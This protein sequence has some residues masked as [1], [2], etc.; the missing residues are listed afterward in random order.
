MEEKLLLEPGSNAL[1]D[2]KKAEL[3]K[4]KERFVF[5]GIDFYYPTGFIATMAR[6]R[7]FC[8]I[9]VPIQKLQVARCN[10]AYWS[11]L[12]RWRIVGEPGM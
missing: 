12:A 11:E 10:V 6:F 8:A 2:Q 4:L 9:W 7:V 3:S 1:V 5:I